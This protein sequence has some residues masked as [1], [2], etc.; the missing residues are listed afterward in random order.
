QIAYIAVI[1]VQIVQR[2]VL[3]IEEAFG[4]QE[5][6]RQVEGPNQLCAAGEDLAGAGRELFDPWFIVL[7]NRSQ[8]LA[9]GG[10]GEECSVARRGRAQHPTDFSAA[11]ALDEGKS[12]ARKRQRRGSTETAEVVG[13]AVADDV[14]EVA[15]DLLS[16]IR[17][18]PSARKAC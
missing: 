11:V 4:V 1:P 14:F 10:V 16:T 17:S 5:Y 15:H 8:Q 6:Q 18:Q 9:G 7:A 2:C 12:A 13:E 3:A